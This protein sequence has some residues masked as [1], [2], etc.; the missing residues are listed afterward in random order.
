[1]SGDAFS[2][3]INTSNFKIFL[4][5]ATMVCLPERGKEGT[6]RGGGG[7]GEKDKAAEFVEN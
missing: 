3:N 4:A 7:G 6:E 1:M 5:S 2:D